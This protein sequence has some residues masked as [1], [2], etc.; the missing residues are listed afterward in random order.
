MH[1][2]AAR[3]EAFSQH[4]VFTPLQSLVALAILACVVANAMI[5][6]KRHLQL[7]G[8]AMIFVG[9]A[10]LVQAP[11]EPVLWA[12]FCAGFFLAAYGRLTRRLWKETRRPTAGRSQQ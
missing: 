3:W 6:F 12:I 5:F 9:L 1:D 10:F 2:M 7:L 11:V 8:V 4:L